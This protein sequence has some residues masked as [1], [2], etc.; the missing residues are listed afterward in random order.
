[1]MT[2]LHV[3]QVTGRYSG[4]IRFVFGSENWGWTGRVLF[5][6]MTLMLLD[7][8]VEILTYPQISSL[9]LLNIKLSYWMME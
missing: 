3:N 7:S 1:M 6:L 9:N 8:I 4:Q 2:L 5:L